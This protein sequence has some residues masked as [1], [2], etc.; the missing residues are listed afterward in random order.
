MNYTGPTNCLLK[1]LFL[2]NRVEFIITSEE[3]KNSHSCNLQ[4]LISLY[5]KNKFDLKPLVEYVE[6]KMTFSI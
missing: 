5:F 2:M 1:L 3:N 6:T 4:I